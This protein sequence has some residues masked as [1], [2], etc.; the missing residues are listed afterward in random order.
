MDGVQILLHFQFRDLK[1]MFK[2]KLKCQIILRQKKIYCLVSGHLRFCSVWEF[3]ASTHIICPV[4]V[5]LFISS[6]PLSPFSLFSTPGPKTPLPSSH[7][8][9]L[10]FHKLLNHVEN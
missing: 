5:P 6:S 2:L 1:E 7:A 9:E 4:C 8:P 3:V 10:S